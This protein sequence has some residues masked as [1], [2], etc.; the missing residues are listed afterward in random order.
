MVKLS[1][2]YNLGDMTREE[3]LE[4][5]IFLHFGDDDY[6]RRARIS[7]NPADVE[8]R[9]LEKNKVFNILRKW[10]KG[11]IEF[12][13][14]FMRRYTPKYKG[15]T[16]PF[17]NIGVTPTLESLHDKYN[18][19]YFGL[20]H[21]RTYADFLRDVENPL[22]HPESFFDK[23]TISS[24]Q[25][26]RWDSMKGKW[27]V[28][29]K[30]GKEPVSTETKNINLYRKQYDSSPTK[31]KYYWTATHINVPFLIADIEYFKENPVYLVEDGSKTPFVAIGGRFYIEEIYKKDETQDSLLNT[32]VASNDSIVLDDI[33]FSDS[34]TGGLDQVIPA[35]FSG[36]LSSDIPEVSTNT[37]VEVN[38]NVPIGVEYPGVNLEGG[39]TGAFYGFGSNGGENFTYDKPLT[40]TPFT[41]TVIGAGAGGIIL[42]GAIAYLLYRGRKK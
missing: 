41:H 21:G 27:I 4:R 37:G 12:T 9:I 23:P 34:N 26:V 36:G 31:Q 22:V 32:V 19:K 16:L 15:R 28:T 35:S 10:S 1:E 30:E 29:Y 20:S 14:E 24:D 17:K 5:Y 3:Y 8:Q 38:P 25:L 42:I 7:N 18:Y 39:N 11:E 2:S 13:P 33:P 6:L 40:S